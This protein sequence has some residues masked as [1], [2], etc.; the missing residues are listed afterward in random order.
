MIPSVTRKKRSWTWPIALGVVA[1]AVAA[2]LAL[3]YFLPTEPVGHVQN[4]AQEPFMTF[5]QPGH[6][7]DM[8]REQAM[9]LDS[10]PLF[11]PTRW[12]T[13]LIGDVDKAV[14]KADFFDSFPQ[15]ISLSSENIRTFPLRGAGAEQSDDQLGP[16]R[17]TPSLGAS[18]EIVARMKLPSRGAFFEV[19]RVSDGQTVLSGTFPS[20]L[21]GAVDGLWQPVD[22]WVR[23]VQA[24]VLGQPLLA[25]SSGVEDL[26]AAL[27]G[28]V[29][30]SEAVALL[31]PGYYSI[32][33]GP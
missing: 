17:V 13:A 21:P 18:A 5:D 25:G 26:D 30:R 16:E 27:R 12:S 2:H 14:Y 8:T 3:L 23:I 10:A 11:L 33:V 7:G 19:S 22:M 20:P 9:L 1:F 29:A 15:E 32:C 24:G 4:E 31:P 6:G 28:L